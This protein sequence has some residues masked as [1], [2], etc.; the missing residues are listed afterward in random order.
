MSD[1]QKRHKEAFLAYLQ[2]D[3]AT[4]ELLPFDMWATD[5][6]GYDL[7]EGW[8]VLSAGGMFP[9]QAEGYLKDFYF[10]LRSE[11]G[12]STLKVSHIKEDVYLNPLWSA[13]LDEETDRVN[14]ALHLL[15]M[16]PRLEKHPFCYEFEGYKV[17]FV[18][19]RPVIDR[20]AKERIPSRG[21]SAEEA[22]ANLS[23]MMEDFF[24]E[25]L[26]MSLEDWRRLIE[27]QEFDPHPVFSDDRVFP[28]KEF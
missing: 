2:A 15:L 6:E 24:L 4:Q 1:F 10:Y 21:S 7:P 3:E 9:F 11:D 27:A 13:R 23:V 12:D 16:V 18:D 14:L 19:G 8:S 20:D 25:R 17:R 26:S 22:F 28:P 5:P